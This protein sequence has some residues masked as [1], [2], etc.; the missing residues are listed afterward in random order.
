MIQI[1]NTIIPVILMLCI[2]VIARRSKLLSREGINALKSI[3]VNITLPA[4]M[5]NAFA[6]M[7]YSVNNIIMTAVMFVSCVVALLLGKLA[8]GGSRFIPFLTTGFEAGMLGY[9]LFMLLYG[10]ENISAFA[11]IDLG[12]VLFVFTL[13]KILLGADSDDKPKASVLVRE[14]LTSPTVIAI[15]CGVILGATGIYRALEGIGV[16][17][18]IDACTDF[19]SAPTGAVILI[20]IGYDLVLSDIPWKSVIRV[21]VS[22]IVIM[23]LLRVA[24]GAVV[25]AIGMGDILDPALNIMFILPPPYVLPVFADD[26]KQRNFVSS[27]L[28]VTTLATI[29]C[30]IILTVTSRY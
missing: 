8:A 15:I 26:E 23:A 27:S 29:V 4:V 28:S 13:Y 25:H 9:S 12:Q 3:V 16:S 20:T 11:Y 2:G 17:S 10:S 22:R 5:L 1:L 7:D 6:T 18:L 21:L 19:V 14:M 30:F 24:V